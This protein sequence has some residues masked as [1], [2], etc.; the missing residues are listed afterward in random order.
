MKLESIVKGAQISSIEEGTLSDEVKCSTDHSP[1]TRT[2]NINWGQFKTI[3]FIDSNIALECLALE[4][5]PW[6]EIDSVGPI[7]VLVAPTVLQE[8]DAKKNHARLGDHARRF[9]R[10]MRPLLGEQSTVRVRQSPTPQVELALADCSRVDWDNLLAL[11]PEEPD[12]RIVAQALHAIGPSQ[13][14]IVVLSQDIRPL[15]LAKQLGLRTHH[16]GENWLRPKEIPESEKK[17]ASLKREL[18]AMKLREPSLSI[19]F[20]READSISTHR[21]RDLT[22]AERRAIH[23]TILS[24][25]PMPEQS[26]NSHGI[27]SAFLNDYDHTLFD[28]HQRWQDQVIPQFVRNFE[29][30]IEINFGQ[31][32][33]V[34]RIKNIGQV[35]AESLLIRLIAD[36]GWINERY[37]LA[38]P[39]GPSAPRIRQ[40][41]LISPMHFQNHTLNAQRQTGKHEFTIL[42]PP[43]R[44][45]EVQISCPDF[46]HGY[47]FEYKMIAWVDP[48]TDKFQLS[49]IVTATNL[50]GDVQDAMTIEQTVIESSASDLL[51]DDNLKFKQQPKTF[52]LLVAA[53]H[54]RNFSK[55]EFDGE[56]WDD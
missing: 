15:H 6:D 12:S 28:R 44:S 45:N 40:R 36:G 43:K 32:E 48:R 39:C 33:I 10:K 26:R 54:E 4:Q 35:P 46:R 50:Y 30:K 47:D 16:I 13:D 34:F 1:H 22:E 9:N 2:M 37:V 53:Q 31:V 29:R 25:H 42:K 56:N 3:A 27:A 11:D 19:T 24:L 55:F 7:L 23:D 49:A 18:D 52:D 20:E 21:I 51:I 5:L 38:N 41:S 14:S 17:A 8:V